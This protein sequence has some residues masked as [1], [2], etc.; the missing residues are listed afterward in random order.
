LSGISLLC[1]SHSQAKQ[2][3][4]QH[5]FHRA[6]R[7]HRGCQESRCFAT[8]IPKPNRSVTSTA[9]IGRRGATVTKP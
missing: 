5:C 7:R 1:H 6:P 9:S 8:V 4:H 3:D 2:I